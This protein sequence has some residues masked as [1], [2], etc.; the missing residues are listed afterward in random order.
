MR[1]QMYGKVYSMQEK[2]WF[3][4]AITPKKCHYLNFH[5]GEDPGS[6]KAFE[7]S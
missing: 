1:S 3:R 2:F 4:R 6:K 7:K 5:C